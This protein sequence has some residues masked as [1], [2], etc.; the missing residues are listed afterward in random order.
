MFSNL[1]NAAETIVQSQGGDNQTCMK[2][3]QHSLIQHS[4]ISSL[5]NRHLHLLLP[6]LLNII[7]MPFQTFKSKPLP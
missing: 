4:R 2:T 7:E 6:L 5:V 3:L 1:E